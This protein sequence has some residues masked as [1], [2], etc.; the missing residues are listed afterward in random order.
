MAVRKG[1]QGKKLASLERDPPQGEFFIIENYKMKKIIE[2][3]LNL[4]YNSN[5][6]DNPLHELSVKD[7]FLNNGLN[8]YKKEKKIPKKQFKK[9][10][11]Q[12]LKNGQFVHQPLGSQNSPDFVLKL[13]NKLYFF[14]CKSSKTFYPTYN[15]GLPSEETIY[16][17]SSV[18]YNKTT[19]YYGSDVISS[20]K[21]MLFLSLTNELKETLKKFKNIPSWKEDSRGFDF[22]IRNMYT[23]SGG[24][25]KTN[26]FNHEDR[27]KCERRVLD[28]FA[29]IPD[30][31]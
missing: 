31:Q 15:S 21:R 27:F 3:I 23:Q 5:S 20:E 16:I 17:F 29:N 30:L 10:L 8:E 25:L 9:L 19:V 2:D 13:N 6:Q 14:E 24:C 7:V 18:R 12:I 28:E 1:K 11:I 26:Y 22:Y 4:P